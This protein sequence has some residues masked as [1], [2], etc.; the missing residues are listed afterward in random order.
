MAVKAGSF[1]PGNTGNVSVS[2]LTFLPTEI[3]FRTGPQS[4]VTD[5][6]KIS[7]CDGWATAANQS[8]DTFY[9]DSTGTQQSAATGKCLYS[10]N[11]VSG[12][13]TAVHDATLV[14]FDTIVPGVSYGFTLNFAT[15]DGSRQIRYIARD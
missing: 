10:L 5:T 8:Y 12:T 3:T 14:S 4:G 9:H 6:G 1:T 11:R 15:Y 7:R 2:G 13:I